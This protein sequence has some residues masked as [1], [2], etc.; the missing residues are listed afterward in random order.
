MRIGPSFIKIGKAV[1][2]PVLELDRWDQ[3]NLVVCRR[4]RSLPF[5][6]GPRVQVRVSDEIAL[7]AGGS[8]P[9]EQ[10]KAFAVV[11]FLAECV[12]VRW[13]AWSRIMFRDNHAK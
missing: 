3:A 13:W 6:E 2:Y 4:A 11:V 1:V 10:P 7:K 5:E 12:L 9:A 8:I